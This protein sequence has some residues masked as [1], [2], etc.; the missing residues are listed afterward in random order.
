LRAPLAW[1]DSRHAAS[2]GYRAARIRT[3]VWR[4]YAQYL[5]QGCARLR[6]G[7]IHSFSDTDISDPCDRLQTA[8]SQSSLAAISISGLCN[9][10]R[11]CP[12]R[13]CHRYRP[14][15]TF[16]SAFRDYLGLCR[17]GIQV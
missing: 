13:K 7:R 9:L 5:A 4:R 12:D 8:V 11:A 10:S 15:A 2:L 6:M 3:D 14:L 17:A 1:Y 16:L